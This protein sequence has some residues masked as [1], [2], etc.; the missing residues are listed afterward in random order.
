V[1]IEYCY[2][3]STTAVKYLAKIR[4]LPWAL[5]KSRLEEAFRALNKLLLPDHEENEYDFEG[6]DMALADERLQTARSML[7]ALFRH[8]SAFQNDHTMK[9]LLLQSTSLPERHDIRDDLVSQA[10]RFMT[11][12]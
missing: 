12:S 3:R 2:Q 9:A 1:V 7:K 8:T 4:L 5:V 11:P 6:E 10:R